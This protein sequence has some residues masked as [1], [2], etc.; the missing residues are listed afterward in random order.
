[1][2]KC[3]VV[4]D[5]KPRTIAYLEG[6]FW[7]Y[8]EKVPLETLKRKLEEKLKFSPIEVMNE[9]NPNLKKF[10]DCSWNIYELREGFVY[11]NKI[12]GFSHYNYFLPK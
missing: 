10:R 6:M 7:E 12:N 3:F 5:N 2:Q 8:N 11:N 9:N 4:V 1:M